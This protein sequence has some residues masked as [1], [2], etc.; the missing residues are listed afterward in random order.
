MAV[1]TLRQQVTGLRRQASGLGRGQV[2]ADALPGA[3]L[4]AM[5][6]TSFL[7][8]PGSFSTQGLNLLLSSAVPLVAASLSQM[9]IIAYGDIDL[10]TGYAV[11]FA[12]AVTARYLAPDPL[13]A[14]GLLLVLVAGYA[15]TAVIVQVR[16]TPSII[17]TLGGSFVWLGWGLVV[18]PIPG[19]TAPGWLAGVFS[20][21]PP[22][23]PSAVIMAAVL[24]VAG[25]VLTSRMS[26]GAVIRGAGSNQATVQRAGWSLL[27]VRVTCY[28]L[29]GIFAAVSGL[30]LTGITSS[31]DPN[32]SANY[33]LLAIAAVILG[34]GEFAGG[35]APALGAVTGALV[36]TLV[37]SLLVFFNVSSSYQAGAQGLIL[38]I[39]LAGRALARHA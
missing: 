13:I 17:V 12:N 38:I 30:A 31:G 22:V 1:T 33:T 35:R 27:R 24:A 20:W 6:I 26:F 8:V 7:V 2:I 14:V 16:R 32:A 10:A 19:G 37:G 39:V 28:V 23:I 3:A 25:Y 36:I 18:L 34:G 4:V 5:L 9:F 11:G 29:A 21:Q 15:I